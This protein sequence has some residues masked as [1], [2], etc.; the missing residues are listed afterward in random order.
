MPICLFCRTTDPLLKNV[1]KADKSRRYED[2]VSYDGVSS[3]GKRPNG[4]LFGGSAQR[5]SKGEISLPKKPPTSIAEIEWGTVPRGSRIGETW[6]KLA[7][8]VQGK[9]RRSSI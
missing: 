5:M 4:S 2:I 8:T 6:G 1:N 7:F 3:P 9:K